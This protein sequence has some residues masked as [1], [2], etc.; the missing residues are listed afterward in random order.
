M[1]H[2]DKHNK[3]LTIEEREQIQVLIS[4]NRTECGGLKIT[5]KKISQIIGK[6]PTT[7]SKELKKRRETRKNPYEKKYRSA[8]TYC[9]DCRNESKCTITKV[10]GTNCNRECKYC[11]NIT[12]G[13][14]EFVQKNCR[15]LE[16]FPY[17]CNGCP[18]RSHCGYDKAY[19]KY[20]DSENEYRR[21]LTESRTGLNMTTL[22]FQKLNR[23]VAEGLDK[24]QS[25][26]IIVQN[27]S[28]IL[29]VGK[30]SIYRY[31][32]K[33]ILSS[34][35]MDTRRMVKMKKRKDPHPNSVVVR[36]AKAGRMYLDFRT[37]MR[38]EMRNDYVMM[39]TVEGVKGGKV[40]LSLY[41]VNCDFQYY[42]LM[43]SKH[44]INTVNALNELKEKLG[45]KYK[46]LFGVILADNGV[47]FSDI[48][49]IEQ[50]PDSM[51]QATK[52]FFCDPMNTNQKSQCERN[53]E[54]LRYILPKGTSFNNLTQ[55]DMKLINSH[56]NSYKRK[57]TDYSSPYELFRTKFGPDVLEKLEVVRIPDNE[58]CLKPKLLKK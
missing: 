8:K 11:F 16:S 33:D 15:Y 9:K 22:Q 38:G 36:K 28:D 2:E 49:G 10:C 13:C 6:D 32:N 17:V 12:E 30:S 4:T 47:E 52:L 53:H 29:P 54:L 24:G 43:K 21:N 7:I 25:V 44:S 14:P 27:N 41:F 42:I 45:D 55:E 1:K 19:Y 23:V 39:D 58:I 40:I 20:T 37:F 31:L 51:E 5:L 46:E 35:K 48:E 57:S 3:H 50:Y 26:D 56:V 34:G 18:R